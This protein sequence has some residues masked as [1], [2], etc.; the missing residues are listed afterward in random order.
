VGSSG[1]DEHNSASG[2]IVRHVAVEELPADNSLVVAL[3]EEPGGGGR[4]L[5]FMVASEFDEQ[6]RALGMD[7]YSLSDE[8]GA[9]VYGGVTSCRL[10]GNTL[11]IVLSSEAAAILGLDQ[12]TRMPLLVPP[13]TITRLARGLRTVLTSG[14]DA[15]APL[16]L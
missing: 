9:T 10:E 11:A 2:F 7:T 14:S 12:A 13:H 4:N 3:A 16:E 8:T 15:S 1:R 6:D 5:L